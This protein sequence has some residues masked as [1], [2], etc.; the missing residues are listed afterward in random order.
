MA[1]KK[2]KL[3]L[4]WIGKDERPRLEPRI[5]L[6]DKEKSYHAEHRVSDCD[7]FNNLLIKGDNLLA[8]KALEQEYTGQVKCIYIDPPYNTGNAFEH[9][10]D[11]I[12][13]S[14]W[15]SLMR[16]R[17]ELLRKLLRPDG[18]ICCH[19]DDSEGHYLKVLMDEVFDRA[20]YLTTFYVQVRYPAKTLKQDMDFHK[21]VEQVHIYRKQY[22]AV[23]NLPSKTSS[24]EK[25][26]YYVKELD[27]GKETIIGGKKAV[28]FQASEYEIYE[29]EGSEFGL[30]EIWASGTILDGNSSGRFFRDYLTGRA[31]Q[32]GL[33][34]L[35]KVFG[36]GDDRFDY[37]YFTGPKRATAT[38]GKYF[39]GVPV[40]QLDN[41][42]ELQY[43]PIENLYDFA[44]QF[45]N[46][47]NE[48]GVDFRGGKKPEILI[49][50]IL[51]H[52]SNENDLVL[53]SF[54]GS[55]T[56]AAVA[57]KMKRRWIMVELGNHA[58][59]HI[60]PRLKDVIDGKDQGGISK[61]VDWNGGGGFRFYE[62]APSL[63]KKDKWDNYIINPEYNAEMLAEA[64]CKHLGFKYEPSDSIYWNHG[65]STESDFIYITT[66]NLT[67]EM[68]QAISDEVGEERTLLICCKAFRAGKTEFPNL[69]L[70]KIPNAILKR[71]EWDKDDY[72]LQVESLKVKEPEPGTQQGLVFD[73]E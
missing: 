60:I 31:V 42:E 6:E 22:G 50:T 32:D 57:H 70:E 46:C 14:L 53:D 16:D 3:E 8:L 45:G 49:Q 15:L 35:Y 25:F 17:L 12:E 67:R 27:E 66:Q 7:I 59:T 21:E 47:R 51:K 1:S 71:C 30:K 4:T 11:G 63:L 36:I 52:F 2:T 58:Y 55:G 18:F 48:G 44:A 24:F 69:T 23:P 40:S 56:T 13:H 62:L 72:S 64:M 43:M 61:A 10:D 54:G 37:R 38:K 68:L 28:V 33:G 20:N 73:E 39:Q 34:V 65:H 19:I 41:P 9:Y 5:L 26:R 29:D